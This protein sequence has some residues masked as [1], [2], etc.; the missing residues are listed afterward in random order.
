MNKSNLIAMVLM[1]VAVGLAVPAKAYANDAIWYDNGVED[2]DCVNPGASSGPEGD[3]GCPFDH[4]KHVARLPQLVGTWN[5]VN[6]TQNGVD[7]NTTGIITFSGNG[8]SY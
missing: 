6:E 1:V 5:I 7:R 3:I 8:S 4:M 2:H